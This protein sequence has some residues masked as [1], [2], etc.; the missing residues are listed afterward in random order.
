MPEVPEAGE[1]ANQQAGRH[2]CSKEAAGEGEPQAGVRHAV[3]D[4]GGHHMEADGAL[5]VPGH[6]AEPPLVRVLHIIHY[7][8]K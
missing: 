7:V 4:P 5:H 8:I 1:T 6:R 2:P 3:L